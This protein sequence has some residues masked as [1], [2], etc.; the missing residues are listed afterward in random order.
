MLTK[1]KNLPFSPKK[2]SVIGGL[3]VER[4]KRHLIYTYMPQLA[5]GESIFGVS[6]NKR[7]TTGETSKKEC[8]RR[9]DC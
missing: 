7:K 9:V 1:S 8:V 6:N 3:W 4:L 5:D 2:I